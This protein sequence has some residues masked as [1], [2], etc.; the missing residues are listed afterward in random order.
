M[1]AQR[2]ITLVGSTSASR[3]LERQAGATVEKIR[4]R[5]FN[6]AATESRGTP[7]IKESEN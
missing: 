1:G 5:T 2:Q 6:L 3:P 7:R 4:E